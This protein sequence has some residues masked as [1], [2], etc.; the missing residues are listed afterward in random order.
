METSLNGKASGW[1]SVNDLLNEHHRGNGLNVNNKPS[2][3]VGEAGQQIARSE[4]TWNGVH[5]TGQ[6]ATV[7]YSFPDWDYNQTNLNSVFFRAD[8]RETGLSAFTAEQ[9]AQAKLSLQSW[10]D[11]ANITFVEV[12]PGHKSDITFG[13]YEGA[14]QA[15]AIKPFTQAGNDY[16]GQ[17]VAG[18]SWY[19]VNYDVADTGDGVYANLHP[20]LG[21]Y[22]R[23]TFTHEIGHTLGLDHPGDY[24][25]GDGATYKS[26]PTYA[27]DTRQFSVM[28][29]WNESYTGGDNGGH[30]AAAPLVDDIAAIQYL[31]GANTSTRVGDSV[32]GFHSN[33]GRDFYTANDSS[34]KLV[35]S[36]WDGGGKDTL[37]F[38]GYSQDQR[39]NLTAGS[40]SDVGGL[41]GNIS[42][43]A[44]VTIENAIGGSG[45]D[46]IV[47]NNA[48]NIIKGGAGNDVIYGGG[49]QDQLSG[50]SGKDIFV[51]AA[52]SDSPYTSPDK[53]LDFET[54]IDKID[55]SFFNHGDKGNDF[56]HF[57]ENL[58]GQAGEA[59]LS[60]NA[61][62]HLSELALNI[63]GNAGPDFLVQIVGQANAATDFIV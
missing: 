21:N 63:H 51:F 62:T 61:Q 36:V 54:G 18:Q 39:I 6:G 15:Y 33:T 4:Q 30:Y 45:N 3:D 14:G 59:L 1:D 40:F 8:D 46:V 17:H 20:D 42:I 44:G 10:A 55:L 13:N 37:D 43:A 57:V 9:Q 53:I 41:K 28:S 24:N 19:N 58:S 11:V 48:A 26:V 7:T 56:I 35:F 31:Y 23:L 27:E 34:Q 49:G 2:F 29:Y 32:Y 47:G 38:S 12:A 16:S 50:G 60:Y 25:A 5:I 52:V 22:G